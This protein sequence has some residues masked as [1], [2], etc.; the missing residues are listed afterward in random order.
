MEDGGGSQQ[1]Q[2]S[3]DNYKSRS[4]FV[5]FGRY[6]DPTSRD[7][8]GTK[9]WLGYNFKRIGWLRNNPFGWTIHADGSLR[10]LGRVFVP[11]FGKLQESV[12]KEFHRSSFD[13]HQGQNNMY[14]DLKWQYLWNGMKAD[15]ARF[16]SMCL[17]CQ[18]VKTEPKT[19]R[20]T[21]TVAYSGLEVGEY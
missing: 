21:S 15:V 19:R 20:I 13:V 4:V 5:C 14:Q 17:T 6:T 18:Q 16:V 7:F 10:F 8:E 1:V 11:D 12:L 9:L 2:P 3:N